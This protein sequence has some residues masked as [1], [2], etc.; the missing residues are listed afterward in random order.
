MS[1]IKSIFRRRE[2]EAIYDVI[3]TT[4]SGS[5][6]F[7]L[8]VVDHTSLYKNCKN[9]LS[10]NLIG[11]YD[12]DFPILKVGD[13]FHL[14]DI[15]EVVV[16]KDIVR[17]SKNTITYYVEDKFIETDRTQKSKKEAQDKICD[18]SKLRSENSE[19]L[20]YKRTHPYEHRF[21]NFIK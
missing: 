11:E 18:W 4:T 2:V 5:S 13:K 12:V 9:I 10:D 16:I 1:S 6:P 20:R 8:T 7:N 19:L 14:N 15:D 21:F 3:R 17:N